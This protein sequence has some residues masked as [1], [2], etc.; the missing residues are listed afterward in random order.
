[1]AA[2]SK[3]NGEEKMAHPKSIRLEAEALSHCAATSKTN[4]V[5][6][7][8]VQRL[9]GIE[10]HLNLNP[11]PRSEAAENNTTQHQRV[12]NATSALIETAEL[13]EAI[14]SY[15]PAVDL[16]IATKVDKSFRKLIFNSPALRRI[17][18]L[19]PQKEVPETLH[20]IEE[21]S[22][23]KKQLTSSPNHNS[24]GVAKTHVDYTIA[25]LCPLLKENGP[26]L[27]FF[28]PL[29]RTECA[30]FHPRTSSA[31]AWANMYLTNPP[32]TEVEVSLCYTNNNTNSNG[33]LP[34]PGLCNVLAKCTIRDFKGI[35]FA[36]L[37]EAPY[38]PGKIVTIHPK[39]DPW[40]D[41]FE[42]M[43]NSTAYEVVEA[44]Q[45]RY[46]CGMALLLKDICIRL[47]GVVF[48]LSADHDDVTLR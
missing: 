5:E 17:L 11:I 14:L 31:H 8:L 26:L 23:W 36:T 6:Q 39:P 22:V 48:E 20:F 27:D 9:F 34:T 30:C 38:V 43:R 37:M 42:V 1:M 21:D 3:L 45:A 19:E 2:Y 33:Q 18:F 28:K 41:D 40:H 15:L 16:V 25:I 32:C 44:C 13:L 46:D 12:E 7:I 35:T 47:V 24:E 10:R 29:Y 4:M